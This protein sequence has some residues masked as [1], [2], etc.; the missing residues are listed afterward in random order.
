MVT[1][2]VDKDEIY[3]VSATVNCA[4]YDASGSTIITCDAGVSVAFKAP[5]RKIVV[6]DD[7]AVLTRLSESSGGSGGSGDFAEHL[8]NST[9][10]V[11]ATEKAM[12]N[13]AA[14]AGLSG[15]ISNSNVHVTSEEKE[16]WTEHTKD[17]D[18]HVSS[19]EKSNWNA[20]VEGGALGHISDADIHVTSEEKSNWNA[21]VDGDVLGHISREDVHVTADERSYWNAKLD[22]PAVY[23][24]IVINPLGTQESNANNY[25]FAY[26]IQRTGYVNS[27]DIYCRS[28]GQAA[29]YPTTITRV[30]VWRGTGELLGT[31][32]NYVAHVTGTMQ[33]Y[34]FKT[35]FYVKKGDELRVSFHTGDNWGVTEY[36]MGKMQCCM[37]CVALTSGESG[38]LLGSD[39]NISNSSYTAK[40]Y[41]YIDAEK[42]TSF[43]HSDDTTIHVTADEKNKLSLVTSH[44][45]DDSIHVTNREKESWN[46]MVDVPDY[47]IEITPAGT[48]EDNYNSYGFVCVMP[49]SGNVDGLTIG[50][51]HSG[52]SG[53]A[54]PIDTP[55]WIKVW[56]GNSELLAVSENSQQHA[57]D[58]ELNYTFVTPF[59]V[60]AGD[61]IRVSFHTADGL[62]TS[63]YQMGVQGCLRSVRLVSGESGGMLGSNGSVANST[64]TAK[65]AWNLLVRHADNPSI[66]VTEEERTR[67]NNAAQKNLGVANAVLITDADGNITASTVITVAELNTLN[68]NTL[69]LKTKLAD[70][71]SRLAAL[72]TA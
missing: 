34:T 43:E 42:F 7:N 44:V 57:L 8:A 23:E 70:L 6:S 36:T 50:C 68:N 22:K 4:V 60:S 65:Y 62:S 16:L 61:E 19:E 71:E 54:T 37:A 67:W 63:T 14:E 29:P 10:H 12:W 11:T 58:A 41:W 9:I 46:A 31:S 72:E 38:G 26:V 66:H 33:T 32:D 21:L 13:K 64:W 56:R 25:G 59:A 40:H 49:K 35:P 51:R 17:V 5:S 52:G 45:E 1:Y 20:L 48:E 53:S 69:N 47:P 55:V 18:V 28:E 3:K 30:K 24:S 39:G 15:H 2:Y 27:V